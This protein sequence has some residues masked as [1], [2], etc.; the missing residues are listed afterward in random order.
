[1]KRGDVK[2]Q[3]PVFYIGKGLIIGTIILTASLSFFLGFLVGNRNPAHRE[4]VPPVTAPV[5]EAEHSPPE[6]A[7]AENYRQTE[8]GEP[9]PAE[10]SPVTQDQVPSVSQHAPDASAGPPLRPSD[11]KHSAPASPRQDAPRVSHAAPEKTDAK[12]ARTSAVTPRNPSA[13]KYTV[14][15]GAFKNPEEADVLKTRMTK[16]GYN[17]F[18]VSSKSKQHEILHKVMVGEYKTRREA[19]VQSIR[20]K[21]TEGLRTFVT[22]VTQEGAIR[23]Q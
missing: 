6:P 21:N 20:L 17:V 16:K 18:V 11:Q 3:T 23:Q 2:R 13:R 14:Q 10:T 19:E 7:A 9:A 4:P 5:R 22:F 1:M 15:V 8:T 12:E